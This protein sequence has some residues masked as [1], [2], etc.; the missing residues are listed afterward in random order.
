MKKKWKGLLIAAVVITVSVINLKIVLND[1]VS[2]KMLRTNFMVIS[3]SGN[4]GNDPIYK[5]D[6]GSCTI[7]GKGEIE[8]FGMG[9]TKVNGRLTIDGKVACYADGEAL[10]TTVDCKDLYMWTQKEN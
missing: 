6:E 1:D 10:C 2:E 3:E 9:I 7:Y 4:T 5:R 8:I